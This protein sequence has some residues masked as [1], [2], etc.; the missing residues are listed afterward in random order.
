MWKV[1]IQYTALGFGPMTSW[2]WV[3]THYHYTRVPALFVFCL[4]HIN[5]IRY[6]TDTYTN[7]HS[8]RS[9]PSLSLSLFFFS[10]SLFLLSLFLSLSLSLFLSLSLS[11]T[12][13][14]LHTFFLAHWT[15][16]SLSHTKLSLVTSICCFC[17]LLKSH[18]CKWF[19]SKHVWPRQNVKNKIPEIFIFHP[20]SAFYLGSRSSH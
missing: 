17:W 9:L 4:P 15:P 7:I 1:S 19:L 10:L 20:Q 16:S 5:V 11:L 12:N 6:Y 14:P 2:T 3:V 18:L 8:I 13:L